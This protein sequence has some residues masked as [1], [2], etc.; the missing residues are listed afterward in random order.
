MAVGGLGVP[1]GLVVAEHLQRGRLLRDVDQHQVIHVVAD[2]ERVVGVGV[3]VVA[4]ERHVDALHDVAVAVRQPHKRDHGVLIDL[5]I[6]RHGLSAAGRDR[7]VVA[8]AAIV[9][10]KVSV[11]RPKLVADRVRLILPK[12]GLTSREAKSSSQM[13]C[14]TRFHGPSWQNEPM[15]LSSGQNWK[16]PTQWVSFSASNQPPPSR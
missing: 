9:E 2:Q 1:R 16:W 13:R 15:V 10:E 8:G 5:H 14:V 12:H 7:A 4:V 11:L 6:G 3:V